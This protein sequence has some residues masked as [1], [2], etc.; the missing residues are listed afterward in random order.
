MSNDEK[1]K[2]TLTKL[3]SS[4]RNKIK[5]PTPFRSDRRNTKPEVPTPTLPGLNLPGMMNKFKSDMTEQKSPSRDK[6]G[7]ETTTIRDDE[8]LVSQS[9]SNYSIRTP[10]LATEKPRFANEECTF[11]RG[12]NIASK[13]E[14][15]FGRKAELQQKINATFGKSGGLH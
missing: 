8:S 10:K 2:P 3:N 9:V 12:A 15:T 1:V 4:E 5:N 7:K 11:G 13:I 6:S 14:Q